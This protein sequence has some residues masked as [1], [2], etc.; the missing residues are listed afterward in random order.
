MRQGG[1][2]LAGEASGVM[3]VERRQG[4]VAGRHGA[5]HKVVGR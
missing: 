2:S 4:N 5:G 1:S 3:S